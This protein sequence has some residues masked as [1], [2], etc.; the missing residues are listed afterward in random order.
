MGTCDPGCKARPLQPLL[1][2]ALTRHCGS[3]HLTGHCGAAHHSSVRSLW[4]ASGSDL[5]MRPK[6]PQIAPSGSF[7]GAQSL[8][9]ITGAPIPAASHA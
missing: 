8:T 4:S 9:K 2:I 1:L 7:I 6:A 5:T 3:T